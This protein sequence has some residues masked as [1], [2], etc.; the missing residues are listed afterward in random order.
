MDCAYCDDPII[1]EPYNGCSDWC[2]RSCDE[3]LYCDDDCA[4]SAGERADQNNY[5]RFHEGV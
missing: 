2:P 5:A 4:C 3:H 1:G